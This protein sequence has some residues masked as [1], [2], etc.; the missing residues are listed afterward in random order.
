MRLYSSK[1]NKLVFHKTTQQNKK[2]HDDHTKSPSVM[3]Q[4]THDC[5]QTLAGLKLVRQLGSK[6]W[7]TN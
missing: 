5:H 1:F 3:L 2:G 4:L 6:P 7:T